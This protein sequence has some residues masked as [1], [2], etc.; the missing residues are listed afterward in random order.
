MPMKRTDLYEAPALLVIPL[1]A[2]GE[3]C[4]TVSDPAKWGPEQD[5]DL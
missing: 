4:V 1:S 3:V 2:E 5:W